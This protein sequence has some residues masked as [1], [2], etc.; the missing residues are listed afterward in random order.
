MD[1]KLSPTEMIDKNIKSVDTLSDK[2][3]LQL[4]KELGIPFKKEKK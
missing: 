2:E 4:L 1:Y 3:A